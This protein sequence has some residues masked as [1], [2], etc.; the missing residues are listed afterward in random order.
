[1][2]KPIIAISEKPHNAVRSKVIDMENYKSSNDIKPYPFPSHQSCLF[3]KGLPD[4]IVQ[5]RDFT[6]NTQNTPSLH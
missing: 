3:N 2:Q 6:T 4:R 5:S 1:M